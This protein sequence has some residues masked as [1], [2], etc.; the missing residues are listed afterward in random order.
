MH[1]SLRGS[2]VLVNEV[3]LH[4]HF[5]ERL[6]ADL[7][8][9]DEETLSDTLE[10]LTDL[11]EMVAAVVRS[12]LGDE[13]IMAGLS[14]RISEMKARLDRFEISARRKRQA[15]LE[16]MSEADI[17][18]LAEVDFTASLKQGAASV[19]IV[20]EDKIPAA[21]WKPQPSKLDKL[22]V[23]AALKAGAMIDGAALIAPRLQLAVRTK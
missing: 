23:L 14:S 19:E 20:A 10:G 8:D 2:P 11:K 12:A 16:A 1:S 17:A 15:A 7:P 18:K 3:R 5:R 6:L 22:G 21:Y 9:L 13:A 4:N